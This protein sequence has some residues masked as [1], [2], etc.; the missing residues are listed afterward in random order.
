[1][2]GPEPELRQQLVERLRQLENRDSEGNRFVD[3]RVEDQLEEILVWLSAVLEE[4]LSVSAEEEEEREEAEASGDLAVAVRPEA[5]ADR[6]MA[7]V[8][9]W[10]SILSYATT[11][12]Y[13]PL[14]PLPDGEAGASPKIV[15]QIRKYTSKLAG[16]AKD[17]AAA[18]GADGW[19]ISVGFPLAGVAVGLSWNV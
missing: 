11:W 19:S 16:P 10:A 9:S 2:R 14:S 3:E 6:T 15:R 4:D 17:A 7:V 13:A 8:E 12:V 5:L 1:M 18:L